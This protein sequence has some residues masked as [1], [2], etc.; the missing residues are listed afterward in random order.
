MDR[1]DFTLCFET[2]CPGDLDNDGHVQ[3][4]DLLIFLQGFSWQFDTADLLEFT[5]LFGNACD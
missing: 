5:G 3:L 1:G 4:S 2:D